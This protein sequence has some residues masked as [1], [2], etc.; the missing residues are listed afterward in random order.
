MLV[1]KE[2]KLNENAEDFLYIKA[3][4]EGIMSFIL[5]LIGIDT[6][7]ELKCNSKDMLF[8]TA[9][10]RKGQS[11]IYIPNTAVTAVMSGFHKPFQLLVAAIVW[12][13]VG[14]GASIG[15]EDGGA[16]VLVVCLVIGGICLLLYI[17]NKSLWFGVYNGGDSPMASILAKRSVI[18]GVKVD[19]E[20]FEKAA[21]LLNRKIRE[22][23]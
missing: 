16:F 11:N 17:L 18:E 4:Q 2:F 20:Q 8:R 7:T 9:S 22:A 3:R 21:V 6:T 23:K 5:S 15:M 14:I 19:F 10:L 13:C 12:L 1:L